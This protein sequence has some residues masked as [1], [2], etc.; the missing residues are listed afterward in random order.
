M[1]TT[2]VIN[3]N[4]RSTPAISAGWVSCAY[5]ASLYVA[6][7]YSSYKIMTSSD[8]LTW[9]ISTFIPT[10]R[11]KKII[12]ASGLF[13]AIGDLNTV[14]ANAS[15]LI[16]T[17]PDGLNWTYRT[18]PKTAPLYAVTYGNGIFV[19]TG[20]G[21][22]LI[23]SSNG[24]EW[25]L[26][27][28]TPI[29]V[30]PGNTLA[31][32]QSVT[33]H[34]EFGNNIFLGI[35]SNFRA[36]QRVI[37]TD[38]GLTW[39]FYTGSAQGE[40]K[41]LMFCN[42][43]NLFYFITSQG[44]VVK[45]ADGINVTRTNIAT[46]L[47]LNAYN[48]IVYGNNMFVI[49]GDNT[50]IGTGCRISY[51]GDNW[52][53]TTMPGATVYSFVGFLNNKFIA[54][55][56]GGPGGQFVVVGT[57]QTKL[58]AVLSNFNDVTR[59][60]TT[61][62][63]VIP[64]PTS[65]HPG[66][67][68]LFLTG[69]SYIGSNYNQ[70]TLNTLVSSGTGTTWVTV[71]QGETT[72]Y[73]LATKTCLLTVNK[74]D[75]V[76]SN[77][78]D[79]IKK[80]GDANFTLTKPTSISNGAFTY[81]ISN[82]SVAT[83]SGS[84]V[85]LVGGGM[86]NITALQA[87]G[88]HPNTGS[89]IYNTASITCSLT[90]N[91]I[92]RGIPTISSF[93]ITEKT[94]GVGSF[95]LPSLTSN[96]IGAITYSSSN[97]S[98]ATISGS[99]VSVVGAGE[100]I[101]T[102]TQA[103]TFNYLSGTTSATLIVIKSIP[104]I[105]SFNITEKTFGT[106]PFELT[107]ISDSPGLFTYISSDTSVATISGSTVSV[108][109]AGFTEIT[110]IQAETSNYL[111]GSTSA[112]LNVIKAMPVL[113]GFASFTKTFGEPLFTLP[114]LISN[115]S[116]E[117]TYS[118]ANT[119]VATISGTNVTIVGAGIA[120][121]TASQ[122]A[123]S[124]F[125]SA[126]KTLTLTVNRRIPT[127]TEI[128]N[129]TKIYGSAPFELSNPTSESTGEFTYS[130][131]HTSV[132]N[133]SGKNI[134]IV[135]AGTATITVIQAETDNF[136]S[137]TKTFIL[138]VS[139]A[140]PVLSGFINLLKT[141]G[142][143]LFSLAIPTSISTG[144]FT[145]SSSNTAIATISGKNVTVV[146]AGETEITATQE[147]TVNYE[148]ATIKSY[149][150]VNKKRPTLSSFMDL[151]KSF[152]TDSFELTAISD[153]SGFIT[154]TSSDTSVATISG[155]TVSV[156]GVGSATIFAIQAETSNYLSGSTS[157][158]LYVI[159]GIPILTGFAS[160]T[161][162]FGEP[163][164][165]LPSLISNSSGEIT[166]SSAN[167]AVATISGTNVTIVGA[168]IAII[169]A[170][171]GATSNFLSASKTLTLTVNR[172][173]PTITEIENLTKIYGSAPF[174]LS[175]PT[176][177]STG[178]FTYSSPHTSVI[179][180]SGKNISIVGAGTATITVIQAETDNFLSVTKTFI[181]TVSKAL[182]VLS[183]FINLLKTFGD[184]LF[185][186]A[187]PTSISTGAFTYSS[188]NTA[189]ATIS[190][191]NVTVVGAGETEITAT[192]E[193]TVN[194][195]SATI[196]SYLTVNK[197]RPTLSGFINLIK[198]FDTGPFEL[199]AIS[200]S[201]GFFTYTSSDTSVAT[202]SGS[203][204]SVVSGGVITII[205]TQEATSNYL[206]GI[207]TCS[208]TI[209][210]KTP[211]LSGFINIKQLLGVSFILEPPTSDSSGV[212]SYL[213]SDPLVATISGNTV[214]TVGLGS[215]IITATQAATSIYASRNKQ[216]ILQVTEK[217]TTLLSNFTN[218]TRPYS[219]L[220][221]EL[222]EPRTNRPDT[223]ITYSSSNP[224][225]ATIFGK[226][227]TII[228]AGSTQISATQEESSTYTSG[229]IVITLTITQSL[230]IL[231][232]F[233][234]INKVAGDPEFSLGG[235][236]STNPNLIT[237]SSSKP[238][239]ATISGTT[240]NPIGGGTTTITASQIATNNFK[241]VTKNVSLIVSKQNTNLYDFFNLTAVY[242]SIPIVLSPPKSNSTGAITYTSSNTLVAS[243]SKNIVTI[244]GVGLT[245]ITA[246]QAATSTHNLATIICDLNVNKKTTVLSK[247]DNITKKFGDAD[248]I[249]N[250]PLSNNPTG[251]FTYT[252]SN[253]NI[254]TII[255]NMVKI[256]GAG[257]VI[258]TATQGETSIFSSATINLTLNVNKKITVLSGFNDITK[259]LGDVDFILNN[260]TSNGSNGDFSYTISDTNIASIEGTTVK[261]MGEGVTI[262]EAIQAET[263]NYT[264]AKISCFLSIID[265]SKEDP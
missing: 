41:S 5:G 194:Y 93:N 33:D 226:T 187:I 169:T 16:L 181:L 19:A 205:A 165:T 88:T 35:S 25:N 228:A 79:I 213:I 186:L 126:S 147:A 122:G 216:C 99:S 112:T 154:Y 84:T 102:A 69:N 157:V 10:L 172:R 219:I 218:I 230:P 160:F 83:I 131:P 27:T 36:F 2:T 231:S 139:K 200:D 166:Y 94:F 236:T 21:N 247:F 211:T 162:T 220:P 195:E 98:V 185:S 71:V 180:I 210:K 196:K 257:S 20:N 38:N 241:A 190:G 29:T 202:I 18:S 63:F 164:F 53:W 12:Y 152:G 249:L 250:K 265:T 254:A 133:I 113:T 237:F 142:D 212:F 197:K 123:T 86:V 117:I 24:I 129:L 104:T 108:V 239:I 248:F 47:T 243:I 14:T 50:P 78:N 62:P 100:T 95:I 158:I 30:T 37:S 115:S 204:V 188:S 96:S 244:R 107:A 252:S 118:S 76:I 193:A 49:V 130:S 223:T 214:T 224:L 43:N 146:G 87:E 132:I 127:I 199:T 103:E 51:D 114:S 167:T 74:A 141:F 57:Q 144:A 208:L 125:L 58:K 68:S 67:F 221:F 258:I 184:S 140:L 40:I 151:I 55:A 89:K 64:Y 34:L 17:S 148:S 238:L 45:T 168:G 182:P 105:S 23:T 134:S 192:Q 26:K 82:T 60:Y 6:V 179:N 149:L 75:I 3:W 155:S 54:L 61:T 101:I 260:I 65:N 227:V 85:T 1:A 242:G 90:V 246:K 264:L 153:S 42:L 170:S 124:N 229:K 240:V 232:N 259:N 59:T 121:I 92:N 255:G 261:I 77:F 178:E 262:I 234:T 207:K 253:T 163:L 7:S 245:Q 135:G 222:I 233:N 206:S 8:G 48:S 91:L 44:F 15:Q 156:M 143:S 70:A 136:L 145:Y 235:V 256:I 120:I 128:E 32:S 175:N 11:I 106:D 263:I 31:L 251:V 73:A 4:N 171:Q 203:T 66:S 217:F 191:K 201:P 81:S 13:V 72:N 183:G 173:I 176:S 177:E 39:I 174:E 215:T 209:N 116:G 137:V 80:V 119:A 46:S 97:T 159:K 225:V 9:T 28:I 109:G 22:S 110:A 52:D 138:T 189:I 150:T 111:S 161:K 56:S 198:S